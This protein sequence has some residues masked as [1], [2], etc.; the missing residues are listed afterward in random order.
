[1]KKFGNI[2][3]GDTITHTAESIS[4]VGR[5]MTEL[6]WHWKKGNSTI[7]TRIP[8][9]AEKAKQEGLRV[10]PKKIPSRILR[11]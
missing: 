9:F 11:Y 7:F 1:M 2:F 3:I 5:K 6:I 8:E 10:I 4:H